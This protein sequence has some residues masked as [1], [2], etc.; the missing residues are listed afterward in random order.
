M[1]ANTVLNKTSRALIGVCALLLLLCVQLPAQSARARMTGTVSD[2]QGA[3]VPG[4][5]VTVINVGTGI[6]SKAITGQDG[7]YETLDLPIGSYKIKVER[8]HFKTTETPAYKLEISQVLKVDV[9]LSLGGRDE[10]VEVTGEASLVE[11]VNPTL[12]ASVTSATIVD[13]PLNGRNVLDL[14][15]LQP[16]VTPHNPDDTS[17]G[18]FNI[19]GSRSDS[20][21]FLLDGGVDNNLLSNGVVY[22]PNPDAIEEFRILTS[23]YTAEYGRNSGG[24]ISLVTKSGTNQIHGSI[25][26]FNRNDTFAANQYFNNKNGIA[27]DPLSRNQ[28]GFTLGGP[29][30]KN[31]LFWFASYQGQKQDAGETILTNTFTPETLV[32]NFSHSGTDASHPN[33]GVPNSS[34]ANFLLNNPFYQSNPALA[35]LGII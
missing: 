11:T 32:G 27:K 30:R 31:K 14:A 20:V 6:E 3:V 13:L 34:V 8:E 9:K 18:S 19:A 25:F 7:H 29:I 24:I 21:T 23:N 28:Y 1:N 35:A 17:A 22:T 33:G 2:P 12:G 4:A 15:A 10:I 5:T 16:G 26:E